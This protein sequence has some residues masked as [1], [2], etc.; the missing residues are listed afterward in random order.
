M[1]PALTA[2]I[3][4]LNVLV[5][6]RAPTDA[7]SVPAPGAGTVVTPVTTL[8]NIVGVVVGA[9][10]AKYGVDASNSAAISGGVV[11][12]LAALLNQLHLTGGANI[13]TLAQNPTQPA[14][15]STP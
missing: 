8:T 1:F 2:I 11:A 12:V 10:L 4:L 3:T 7:P 9:V 15:D 14:K 5:P 6:F 13:N